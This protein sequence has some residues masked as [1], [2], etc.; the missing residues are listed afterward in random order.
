M[1]LSIIYIS[2]AAVVIFEMNRMI[3]IMMTKMTITKIIRKVS[4]IVTFK[5]MMMVIVMVTAIVTF[6]ESSLAQF[7]TIFNFY[8]PWKRLKNPKGFLTSSRGI[9][10][11]QWSRMGWKNKKKCQNIFVR[12]KRNREFITVTYF[13]TYTK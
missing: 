9:E 8:T 11:E 4:V 1:L 7:T 6:S 2:M 12:K 3:I 10:V 5:T 13:Q